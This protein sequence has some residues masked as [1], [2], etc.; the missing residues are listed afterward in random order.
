[1]RKKN[2]NLHLEECEFWFDMRNWY[3]NGFML[4][5]LRK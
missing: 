3:T 2:F 1:M 5:T 4:T